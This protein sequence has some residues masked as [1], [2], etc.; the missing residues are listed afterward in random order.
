MNKWFHSKADHYENNITC[1]NPKI[2]YKFYVLKGVDG[3]VFNFE[4]HTGKI[5][6]CP[7]Q[8]NVGASGN[9]MFAVLNHN[10]T[11]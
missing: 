10:I 7:N 4:I 1:K 8:P 9:I 11:P 6:C 2:G 3:Q 5:E